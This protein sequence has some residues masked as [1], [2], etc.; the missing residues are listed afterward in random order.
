LPGPHER[1]T[2]R[3]TKFSS[4]GRNFS[5]TTFTQ[6]MALDEAE[7]KLKPVPFP[8]FPLK[9]NTG[10]TSPVKP[11]K[12]KPTHLIAYRT[13]KPKKVRFPKRF[14]VQKTVAPK[15]IY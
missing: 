15:L 14:I 7:P 2:T 5:M 10:H 3:P 6:F 4:A 8:R 9:F 1:N 13:P 12:P 11:W